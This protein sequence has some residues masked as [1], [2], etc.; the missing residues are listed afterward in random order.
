MAWNLVLC[1]T[2]SFI[3]A[4]LAPCSLI[5]VAQLKLL[6]TPFQDAFLH[7]PDVPWPTKE[8]ATVRVVGEGAG[9]MTFILL[10]EAGHFVRDSLWCF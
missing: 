8:E 10:A 2:H 7:T 9:N 4:R 5:S 3:H 6:Q 1:M